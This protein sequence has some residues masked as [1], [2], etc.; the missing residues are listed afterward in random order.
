LRTTKL[1]RIRRVPLPAARALLAGLTLLAAAGCTGE[2]RFKPLENVDYSLEDWRFGRSHGRLLRTAHYEIH[3]TVRDEELAKALPQAMETAYAYYR[4]LLPGAGEPA[5]PMQVYLF[6]ARPEFESFTRRTFP[7]KAEKLLQVRSGGYSEGGVTVIEYVAHEATFAIMAH[8]GFHQFVHHCV[9]QPIPAWLNE[10]LAVWCEGQR[11]GQAGLKEFDPWYNPVRRSDLAEALQREQAFPLRELL[12]INAGNVIGGPTSR[13]GTY[14]GQLLALML[15]L[16]DGARDRD[17]KPRY[18]AG[19][20]RLLGAVG[21]KDLEAYA[22]AA[23]VSSDRPE[24]HFGEALFRSFITDDLETFE[25]EFNEFCR[26]LLL[27]RR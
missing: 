26:G 8:E 10:G 6:A 18:A 14:Y 13:I 25:S 2:K 5:A 20:E 27:A 9:R 21:A 1:K 23:F 17:G 19:F 15:F 11:W 4:F 7:E 16:K 12:R 24:Y 3:T 22:Q